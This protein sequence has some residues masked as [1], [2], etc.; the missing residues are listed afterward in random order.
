MIKTEGLT[1]Q[2]SKGKKEAPITAVEGLTLEVKEGE[3]FG[4]LGPNGAGKTTTVRMLTSLIAPTGGR[5]TVNGLEVGRQD[6][7]IRQC[8]GILTETPGMYDRLSADQKPD[9]LRPALWGQGRVRAGGEVPAHAGAVGAALRRGG[10]LL[11][12][13]A[14]EAGDRPGAAAR[15][16]GALSGRADQRSG[17]GSRQAGARFHRGA[18]N[19]GHHHFPV[20][21]QPGRGRP[22]VR[23]HRHLQDAPDHGRF[24]R[25]PAQAPVWAQG[26]LPPQR[27]STR[28]W[29]ELLK[30]LPFVKEAQ[31][32][33]NRLVVGLDQPEEQNPVMLRTPGRG[34]GRP[35]SSSASCATRWKMFTCK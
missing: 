22:A 8:V 12:G 21:P 20:H 7:E 25:Q 27:P 6:Q 30:G 28:D 23:A 2:F 19:G 29:V 5:A 14:P 16:E 34:W 33:E 4:F 17:P 9:H 1:K 32:V 11:K 26:G 18:Q 24:A 3:V 35:S 31:A 15:A 10:Q 13:H